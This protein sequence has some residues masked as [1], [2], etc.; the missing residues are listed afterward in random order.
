MSLSTSTLDHLLEAES[1]LRAAIKSASCNESPIVIYNLSRILSDIDS[2]KKLENLMDM[3][4][5]HSKPGGKNPF[6]M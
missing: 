3:L 5:K 6:G 2:I 4:D 1:H